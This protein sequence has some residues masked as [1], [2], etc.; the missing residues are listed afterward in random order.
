MKNILELNAEIEKLFNPEIQYYSQFKNILFN[1]KWVNEIDNNYFDELEKRIKDKINLIADLES[2]QIIKY[3]KIFNEDLLKK[4]R[5]NLTIEYEN[6]DKLNLLTKVIL[7][8]HEETIIK[9]KEQC[10][11][12]NFNYI[13]DYEPYFNTMLKIYKI[14]RE[15][16][17]YFNAIE[18]SDAIAYIEEDIK[19]KYQLHENE[20]DAIVEYYAFAHL[21]ICLSAQRDVI[22]RIAEYFNN[23]INVISKIESF[24]DDKLSLEEIYDNDPTNIKLEY[25][26]NKME[27]AFFYRA[28]HDAGILFVD[29]KNQKY[30]YT[31]L[32]KYINKSNIYYL[33]NN[34][35]EKIDNINKE[36]SKINS[37][38]YKT[39]EMKMLE[40]VISK[41]NTRKEVLLSD[42]E[43]GIL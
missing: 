19:E 7:F 20:E 21:S 13:D 14:G 9:P 1:D 10:S 31:N 27:V 11:V 22:V 29:N 24:K 39:Q 8:V 37:N 25:R 6:L 38:E 28:L 35:V 23:L 12:L 42:K 33:E 4:Y 17:D 41:L 15:W 30:P 18:L 34:K 36:F 5:N 16:Y 26:I 3:L 43:E 32:K 2:L 40:L